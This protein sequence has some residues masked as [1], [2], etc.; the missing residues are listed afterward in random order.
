[1]NHNN[2]PPKSQTLKQQKA[3]SI[4]D[5][6]LN[7]SRKFNLIFNCAY[8]K[9][10]LTNSVKITKSQIAFYTGTSVRQVHNVFR[11]LEDM[12]LVT[13][14]G[15]RISYDYSEV[16]TYFFNEQMLTE[17]VRGFLSV[18]FKSFYAFALSSLFSISAS[19]QHCIPNI[20][21]GSLL[22]IN[23]EEN[24][25]MK[26]VK[27]V[28]FGTDWSRQADIGLS[29]TAPPRIPGGTP[30]SSSASLEAKSLKRDD[31]SCSNTWLCHCKVCAVTFCKWTKRWFIDCSCR[32]CR[33]KKGALTREAMR[34]S[35]RPM[36]KDK[37]ISFC[38]RGPSCNCMGCYNLFCKTAGNL[39][40]YCKCKECK[41]IHDM[42]EA[43]EAQDWSW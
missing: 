19:S 18:F 41:P 34:E 28:P 2:T 40:E 32:K 24:D 36:S 20:N 37:A 33:E 35:W 7:A 8:S 3:L 43:I 23:N 12:G 42:V 38:R 39:R 15:R 22:Y 1:M 4:R 14:V 10:I 25:V 9:S 16:N 31:E 27:N 29:K 17:E 13:K 6:V 21:K 5:L 30:P 26:H 11:K